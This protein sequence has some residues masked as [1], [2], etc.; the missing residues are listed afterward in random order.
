M[1]VINL[2]IPIIYLVN[3]SDLDKNYKLLKNDFYKDMFSC[4]I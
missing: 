1:P 4:F 2:K 3:K